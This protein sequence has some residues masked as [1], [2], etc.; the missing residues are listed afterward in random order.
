VVRGR[1]VP[2]DGARRGRGCRRSRQPRG[3]GVL[4]EAHELPVAQPDL[5]AR[6]RYREL[7]LRLSEFGS[8]YRYEKS[9]TLTAS[10]ACAG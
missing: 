5:L 8:V 10:R 3:P 7:P 6:P 2:A 1:H 9:G 4:P